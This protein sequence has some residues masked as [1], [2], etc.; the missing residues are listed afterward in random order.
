MNELIQPHKELEARTRTKGD[1]CIV[2]WYEVVNGTLPTPIDHFEGKT[3]A[4]KEYLNGKKE[5]VAVEF[6]MDGSLG[7]DGAWMVF[8]ERRDHKWTQMQAEHN[9][10]VLNNLDKPQKWPRVG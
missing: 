9:R 4:T 10:A 1:M 5:S 8:E 6:E 3:F 2:A 7:W